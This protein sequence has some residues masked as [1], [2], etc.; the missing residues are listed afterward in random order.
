MAKMVKC[1]N[2][3]PG[4]LGFHSLPEKGKDGVPDFTTV[5]FFHAPAAVVEATD[6]DS[7]VIP[8]RF[9]IPEDKLK[10][11]LEEDDFTKHHFTSGRCR[12]DQDPTVTL[13]TESKADDSK[14]AADKGAKGK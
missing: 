2:M 4:A 1:L 13:E 3:A 9:E 7:K 10:R 11:L 5:K 6:K 12:I 8:G 14:P